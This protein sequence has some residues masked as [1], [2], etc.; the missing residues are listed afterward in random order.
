MNTS[1]ILWI[2]LQ[3]SLYCLFKRTAQTLG[4]HFKVKRWSFEHDLDESCDVDSVHSHLRQTIE[5]SSSPVH[6]VGHGISG[7]IAHLY[8]QKYPKNIS[9]ISLLSV[10][11]QSTN[12][13]TSHYQRMRSQLQ[14]SR[15][16]ILNHLSRLLI[17]IQ[18]DHVQDIITKLLVKC[19]D[20]DFVNGSIVEKPNIENLGRINA[21][22]LVVNGK[23]D[24]VVDKN[25]RQRW[26][27]QLKPG[28]CYKE[29]KNGRHFFPFH[30]WSET[31]KI[32][33]SFITMVP[34]KN[35]DLDFHFSRSLKTSA[36]HHHD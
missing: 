36:M 19:L 31:A 33:D 17:E 4:Q 25:S 24:F 28:D 29:I 15:F 35:Q 34:E 3:P 10:D 21:P 23:K 20:N 16:H 2:D 11:V 13:W 32:I 7:T 6:L 30:D 1:Q 27:Q 14:C 9:S 18:E 22:I 5:N 26:E 8:A 12:Q